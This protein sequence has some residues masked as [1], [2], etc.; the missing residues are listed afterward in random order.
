MKP[1]M[2]ESF[3]RMFSKMT[4]TDLIKV[5]D[6]LMRYGYNFRIKRYGNKVFP[7]YENPN[8]V[9]SVMQRVANTK[10]IELDLRQTNY[11]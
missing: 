8:L 7:I 4:V 1:K 10:N 2:I 9:D 11:V 6:Q 3:E 5:T